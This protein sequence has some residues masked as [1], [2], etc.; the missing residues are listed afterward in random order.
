MRIPIQ[1]YFE[2]IAPN[3]AIAVK[4]AFL[5]SEYPDITNR[6]LEDLGLDTTIAGDVDVDL[7]LEE[8]SDIANMQEAVR[9]RKKGFDLPYWP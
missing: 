3:S 2:T 9:E 5:Y 6:V 7:F 8:T 4:Q 1:S